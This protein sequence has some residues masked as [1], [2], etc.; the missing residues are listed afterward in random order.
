V[1]YLFYRAGVLRLAPASLR[2]PYLVVPPAFGKRT[3]SFSPAPGPGDDE[4]E[5]ARYFRG[6]KVYVN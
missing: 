4:T 1:F 5:E 6:T 3:L 2:P